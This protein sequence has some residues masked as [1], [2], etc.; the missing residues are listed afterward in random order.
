M[1]AARVYNI[2][3]LPD[4]VLCSIISLLPGEEAVRTSV[5]S[6]RWRYLFTLMT[7]LNFEMDNFYDDYYDEEEKLDQFLDFLDRLVLL[8][9]MVSSILRFRV[10]FRGY[11]DP[12]RVN[13]WVDALARNKIEEL[14]LQLTYESEEV[15]LYSSEFGGFSLPATLFSCES[16]VVLK[17][18]LH[19]FYDLST[20][21][22]VFLPRLEVIH[23]KEIWFS[24]DDCDGK[25]FSS[26]PVLEDLVF[27]ECHFR[28]GCSKLIIS[29]Q[30]LKRLSLKYMTNEYN[31]EE[32]SSSIVSVVIN[33][34]SLVRLDHSLK[35][36]FPLVL[37]DV[38]SLAEAALDF[39]PNWPDNHVSSAAGVLRGIQNIA[40]LE[41]PY[42]VLKDLQSSNAD[43][44]LFEKLTCLKLWDTA[45]GFINSIPLE[46]FLARCVVLEK[47]V[48][49]GISKVLIKLD[50]GTKLSLRTS[51]LAPLLRHLKTI[52]IQLHCIAN[53][54]AFMELIEFFLGNASVLEELRLES[55]E[56][57]Q[58]EIQRKLFRIPRVSKICKIICCRK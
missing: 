57:D 22:V 53:A 3:H 47:L 30:N 51:S 18:D 14:V 16:L 42:H 54:E 33:A 52:E 23:L 19:H 9:E 56:G 13:G 28:K 1:A 15:D 58:T 34:P 11:I 36:D 24:K 25:L 44:P 49:E 45:V 17:V 7:N 32:G 2:N 10:S 50:V 31:E 37:L 4:E 43:I 41:I 38:N 35:M 46:Y 48:I 55:V 21:A 20:P 27:D 29:N 40:M 5:L 39:D 6:K 12:L 26:C 8:Q